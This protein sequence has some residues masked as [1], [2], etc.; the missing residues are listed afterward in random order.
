[1][2]KRYINTYHYYYIDRQH[3]LT[4]WAL[5]RCLIQH[6]LQMNEWSFTHIETN[7]WIHREGATL[8][9]DVI[10]IIKRCIAYVLQCIYKFKNSFDNWWISLMLDR[11]FTFINLKDNAA[12]QHWCQILRIMNK[13]PPQSQGSHRVWKTGGKNMVE[14]KS[15]KFF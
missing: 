15:E 14:E 12:P 9:R 2:I 4:W 6:G 7:V 3:V 1:M 10:L 5:C 13:T 11:C 8:T